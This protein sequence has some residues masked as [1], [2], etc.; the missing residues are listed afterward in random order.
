MIFE[1][2]LNVCLILD[3]LYFYLYFDL[4]TYVYRFI[5]SWVLNTSNDLW[6][7]AFDIYCKNP[8]LSFQ[9]SNRFINLYYVKNHFAI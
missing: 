8:Y 2:I 1:Q 5:D 4:F 6:D 3:G 9:T 7:S